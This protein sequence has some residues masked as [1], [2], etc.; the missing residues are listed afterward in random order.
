M[1]DQLS[2][3]PPNLGVS[4]I[5]EWTKDLNIIIALIEVE[6]CW[7]TIDEMEATGIPDYRKH[8]F[9]GLDSLSL[10]FRNPSVWP[11]P[12]QL[13][14]WI[15]IEPGLIKDHDIVSESILLTVQHGKKF[16]RECSQIQWVN[17]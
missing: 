5:G 16:S 13:V 1:D 7:E 14:V 15:E 4:P 11:K 10:A 9:F 12:D 6:S 8:R 2:I 17:V 3:R